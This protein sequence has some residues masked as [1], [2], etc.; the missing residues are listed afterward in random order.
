M[1]SSA[2]IR[3]QIT[4]TENEISS[5]VQESRR[6]QERIEDLEN[7][8]RRLDEI[9]DEISGAVSGRSHGRFM[10]IPLESGKG[11]KRIREFREE[12]MKSYLSSKVNGHADDKHKVLE[13]MILREKKALEENEARLAEL[14]SRLPVLHAALQAA[15]AAESAAANAA[16]EGANAK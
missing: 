10:S 11:L 13:K 4:D 16:K 6:L 2:A 5:R 9:M 7:R 8:S 15:L 14:R 1:S 3:R 12:F